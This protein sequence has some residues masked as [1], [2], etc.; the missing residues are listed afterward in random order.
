MYR[1]LFAC[2]YC[3]LLWNIDVEDDLDNILVESDEED[4]DLDEFEQSDSDGDLAR[5][6]DVDN[7]IFRKYYLS[8]GS[9]A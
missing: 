3:I 8:K 1:P 7:R 6:V 9:N 4:D 5:D 2:L